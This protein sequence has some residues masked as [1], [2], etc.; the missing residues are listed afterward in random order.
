MSRQYTA[1]LL[2]A[3]FLFAAI[4]TVH[5]AT[6]P[7]AQIHISALRAISSTGGSV[8]FSDANPVY[9]LGANAWGDSVGL[10][11]KDS[12]V[13]NGAL[14]ST[15]AFDAKSLYGSAAMHSDRTVDMAVGIDPSSSP[16]ARPLGERYHAQSTWQSG[17]FNWYSTTPG[18]VR[19]ELDY[20][21]TIDNPA[22]WT[23]TSFIAVLEMNADVPD[24]KYYDAYV[25][26]S[27][28]ASDSGAYNGTLSLDY[29]SYPTFPAW[30][31]MSARMEMQT[32]STV[33]EPSE[34]SLL[35]GGLGVLVWASRRRA[36]ADAST[37]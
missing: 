14:E 20:T 17:T 37:L 8:V 29:A 27:F 26:R 19:F 2:P 25:Y 24:D 5:A 18:T 30:L 32:T 21:V 34:L 28:V 13:T 9:T 15:V 4:P 22:T 6:E 11:G 12:L 16:S 23:G 31:S 10:V 36:Q 35:I 1:R 7:H 33:P 3:L